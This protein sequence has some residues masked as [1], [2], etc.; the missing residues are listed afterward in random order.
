M[1]KPADEER[2]ELIDVREAIV[3]RPN[4]LLD[5]FRD[6]HLLRASKGGKVCEK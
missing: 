2:G 5:T 6:S 3:R 1:L 4:K